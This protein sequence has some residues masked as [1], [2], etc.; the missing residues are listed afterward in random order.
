MDAI[1]PEELREAASR[2][3]ADTVDRR[4]PWG[5]A[6]PQ[7]NA[8]AARAAAVP[9]EA[10]MV[11]LGWYMLTVPEAQGG[12]GQGFGALAPIYEEMGRALAPVWLADTM[13]AI[14][15][16]MLD[17]SGAALPL[18]KRIAQGSA[19]VL[20][21][22]VA[23]TGASLSASLPMVVGAL[24][25]TDLLLVQSDGMGPAVLISRDQAGVAI[26]PI[27]T[28]DRGRDYGTVVLDDAQSVQLTCD[29][30]LALRT[31]QAH[32]HL[33]LACDCVGGTDQ[34]LAETIAYTSTRKQFGQ[35]VGAFQALK[36]RAADHKVHLEVARALTRL[37]SVAYANR[38]AVEGDDQSAGN[39]W[40]MLAAQ[41][42]LLAG[43]AYATTAEDAVQMF[44]GVGFTWEYDCHL[45]LK[46]ALASQTITQHPDRIRDDIALAIMRGA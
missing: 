5:E 46:R 38:S 7:A 42:R 27:E 17:E 44:G 35:P 25:A 14:D 10:A 43:D 26:M 12:M 30:A 40:Q 16:L 31:V 36:H 19:R 39:D 4:A 8:T 6:A 15:V 2:L 45:F 18:L 13:A 23:C 28:W 33:A 1:E 20:V 34:I 21:A 3:L 11:E 41:A 29:G 37:A 9:L 24:A 32:R 22:E